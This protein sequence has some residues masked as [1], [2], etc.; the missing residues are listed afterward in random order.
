[1]DAFQ[2][3]DKGKNKA[4]RIAKPT[5]TPPLPGMAKLNVDAAWVSKTNA[6]MGA[7]LRNHKGDWITGMTKK[8]F[9]NSVI[10][11]ELIA[12]REGILLAKE[13]WL[14]NIDVET[15]SL[16]AKDRLQNWKNETRE[17]MGIIIADVANLLLDD[18]IKLYHVGRDANRVAR[19]RQLALT[20]L[21]Q[22]ISALCL[23]GCLRI[24]R[25]MNETARTTSRSDHGSLIIY[26]LM[27]TFV[28]VL[29]MFLFSVCLLLCNSESPSPQYGGSG[30]LFVIFLLHN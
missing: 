21:F 6:G 14:D 30:Y 27:L 11:T 26:S 22:S 19:Y 23:I 28:V 13:V 18:K 15:D 7:V 24:T 29:S 25:L 20:I 4:V 8:V 17:E 3:N 16:A 1:M 5:W 9:A 10:E 12:L 2:A